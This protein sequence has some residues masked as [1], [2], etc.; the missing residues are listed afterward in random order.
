MG[1]PASQNLLYSLPASACVWVPPHCALR[2]GASRKGYT[3]AWPHPLHHKS[4]T[5]QGAPGGP[6]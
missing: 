6:G 5:T 2:L 4:R 3:A 1:P